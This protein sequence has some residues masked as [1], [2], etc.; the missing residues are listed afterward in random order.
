[1]MLV[2]NTICLFP[3]LTYT[4][5]FLLL[6]A[7]AF[8]DPPFWDAPRDKRVRDD[9]HLG[10]LYHDFVKLEFRRRPLQ[11]LHWE[12]IRGEVASECERD[13]TDPMHSP[14]TAC[15]ALRQSR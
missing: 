11:G 14:R 6:V 1:M 8:L 15:A 9:P 4:P 10:A 2:L 5:S 3:Y 12:L 13:R 7:L